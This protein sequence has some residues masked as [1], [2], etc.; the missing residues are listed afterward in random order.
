MEYEY[1][2]PEAAP[3]PGQISAPQ[4]EV[5]PPFSASASEKIA[6]LAMYLL[7][8]CYVRMW[9]ETEYGRVLLCAFTLGF[10]ALT[11]YLHRRTARSRES[12]VWLGCVAALLL[13]IV[14]DRC[15][16]WDNGEPMLL[17]HVFA[18][19]WVLSRSGTLLEGESGHL[20]PADALDGFVIFPFGH[21]PLR[22]RCLAAAVGAWRGERKKLSAVTAVWTVLA[23]AFAAALLVTAAN[24]LMAADRGFA[25]LLDGLVGQLGWEWDSWRLIELLLSLPVGA[26]LFG[27]IAGTAREDRSRLRARGEGVKD[28][29]VQFRQV[30]RAV[31][32][33]MAALFCV[34]YCAFFV[35]QGS[36]LFGAFTRS[37]PDGFV[38][39]E[40][41]RQGFFELCKVMAVNFALLWLVTRTSR[42]EGNSDRGVKALCLVLLGQSL[43]FAVIA[44][45]KLAL[46][47]DCFGFTPKRLQS[48]WLVC[49]LGCGC[50]CAAVSLLSGKKT[51]RVWMMFGAVT[52]ALLC[53]Y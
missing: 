9:S 37:L 12:W 23:L 20:L 1:G 46:Y 35:V 41:A 34:L 4:N 38:V 43:L 51:M 15:R 11:E 17:L 22:L 28:T 24:L 47:I 50:I 48:S 33:A 8:Y 45:S 42:P 6:A 16:A 53:L 3:A 13:S 14:L 26:Y 39:A 5:K 44:L 7:A 29:L 10:V 31:W 40:Y 49:V 21:F 30:P 18:V 36:Y 19:W 2:S 32:T 52:L 25:D 27:L